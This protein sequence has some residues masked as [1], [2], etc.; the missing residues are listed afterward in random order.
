MWPLG[1]LWQPA[2]AQV[3]LTCEWSTVITGVQVITP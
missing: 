3:P 1:K 2:L